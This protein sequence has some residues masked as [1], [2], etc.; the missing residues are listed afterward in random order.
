[1]E[2]TKMNFR[3]VIIL[4]QKELVQ[5]PKNFI[6]ILALGMPLLFSLIVS[7]VFGTFFSGQAGLGV[8][9]ESNS[10]FRRLV[11]ENQAVRVSSYGTI[12]DLKSAV[13]RGAE[14]LG[15][16]LPG[17]FERQISANQ[18]VRIT[19][20]VWGESYLQDRVVLSAA[21][22]SAVRQMAGQ[23]A[24]V[25][26]VQNMLGEGVNIP[27]EKRLLPLMVMMTILVGGTMIPSTS[28]VNEKT[29]H[30][31]SALSVSPATLLDIFAAKTILGMLLSIF[32]G[33]LILFLNQSFGGQPLLLVLVLALGSMFSA[34]IGV[35]LG[36]LAKDINTLFAT[37]KGM[38]IFLYAPGFV[39]MFPEIPQWIG[40]IFPTYYIIQPVLALT[41]ENAGLGDIYLEL[42]V[43]VGLILLM[44][45]VVVGMSRRLQEA[46][47]MV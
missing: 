14:D 26:I 17:D 43:L 38:G 21:L 33:L 4:L 22:V 23:E 36:I 24:P 28:L 7:L 13:E 35:V 25:E 5:G 44:F 41:Q 1:M 3:R 6:F 40:Q 46:E 9:D 47:A 8:V 2:E 15:V 27:W 16:W 11:S 20:F 31:L 30:T 10:A 42:L 32:S 37:I 45:V 29:H 18:P 39:Y 19:A 12:A 34:T